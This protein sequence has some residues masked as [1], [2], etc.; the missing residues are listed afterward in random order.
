MAVSLQG[1]DDARTPTAGAH[2]PGLDGLRAVAV[3]AVLGYHLWPDLVPGGFLGVTVFFVLSGFLITRLLLAEHDATTTISL[4]GFWGRRARRLL[5]A[6]LAT[7]VVVSAIWMLEGWL[8]R[9]FAADILWSLADLANW[10]TLAS[11]ATYGAAGVD[12]PVLHFWS[13]AIEEQCYLV[14]PLVAWAVLRWRGW[15]VRTLGRVV[16]VLLAASLAYTAVHRGDANLVYLST[17]SRVAELL[18]GVLLAVAVARRGHLPT[19][20]AWPVVGVARGRRPAGRHGDDDA[21]CTDLRPRRSVHRG[22]AGRDRAGRCDD[23]RSAG[24]GAGRG[25]AALHRTDQLRRLPLPLADP[26]GVPGGRARRLV[27]GS[28]HAG[29]HLRVGRAVDGGARGPDPRPEAGAA[30]PGPVR[31]GRRRHDRGDL[32]VRRRA[33]IGRPRLRH[34]AV[35]VRR[36]RQRDRRPARRRHRRSG[37]RR[38]RRPGRLPELATDH[39]RAAARPPRRAPCPDRR[40]WCSATRRR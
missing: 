33:A 14:L 9:A 10:H 11:G 2:L 22:A 30:G 38:A 37:R 27:R 18:V 16:T 35:R 23:R 26:H 5:P 24:S 39:R 32:R 25:A 3:L 7:L 29:C 8:T 17:F 34:G 21:R 31:A 6:S 20:R 28:R 15:S 19:D 4:R 40:S 1:V 13:L 36:T 12:S